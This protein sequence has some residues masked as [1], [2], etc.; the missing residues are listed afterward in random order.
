MGIEELSGGFGFGTEDLVRV[1]FGG[2]AKARVR[3]DRGRQGFG[4]LVG[5]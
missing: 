2:N 4:L 5:V 3:F 1:V